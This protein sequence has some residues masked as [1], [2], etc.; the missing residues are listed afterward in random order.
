MELRQLYYFVTL[1]SELSFT[2]A[3]ETLGIT[4]PTLSQQ[5]KVLEDEVGVQLFERLGRKITVTDAGIILNREC[6]IIFNS[7]DNAKNEISALKQI[8][9]GR[10]AVG[11]LP[12]GLTDLVSSLLP[13]FHQ[14]YP[15]VQIKTMS[16]T[17]IT[18]LIAFNKVDFALAK[19]PLD[20]KNMIQIPLYTEG[21]Y[22]VV[23][24]QNPFAN[25]EQI[26]LKELENIPLILFSDGY[27]CP[28]L[29]KQY[30][31]LHLKVETSSMGSLLN[32]VKS[33]QGA[34]ILSKTLLEMY[35]YVE[36]SAIPILQPHMDR[37]IGLVFHR[38][39]FWGPGAKYFVELLTK[40]IIRLMGPI[41]EE[42]QN[43]L[44]KLTY[45]QH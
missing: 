30:A 44:K 5:I 29:F 45:I 1:C 40:E 25:K 22:L 34:A 28:E 35:S 39:K 36:L 11:A 10:V 9:G 13:I 12:G 21:F 43:Q 16:S 19:F 32:L 24:N 20:D 27:D 4:Q 23:S 15:E 33:G 18:E 31:N 37:N 3:A 42:S 7:I 14:V 8:K 38:D 41:S 6:R 2:R 17:N 26:S